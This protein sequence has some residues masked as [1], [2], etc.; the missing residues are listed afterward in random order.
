MSTVTFIVDPALGSRTQQIPQNGTH[1][2]APSEVLL[3]AA[4]GFMASACLSVF[5][6]LRIADLLGDSSKSVVELATAAGAD[7]DS[8]FRVLRA[9]EP[10]GI[11]RRT[12]PRAFA[13]TPAGALLQC[14][15]PQSMA[16]AIE[17]L[18]DPLHFQLYG[19]LRSSIDTGETTFDRLY[20]EPFFDWTSRS[21][22][23]GQATVFN[24]AMTSI[25]EMCIPAFL[26]AY[27]FSSF[28]TIVDVGGGHGA[29]LRAILKNHP[30][31]RGM[32][33]E[34]ESVVSDA[35]AAIRRD[36]LAS[37]CKAVPC[38]FFEKV[39]AGGDA[40]FM[41]H[42][43]HDWADEPAGRLLRCCWP[44]VCSTIPRRRTP[45]NSLTLK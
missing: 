39:P 28:G 25:S 16:A 45:G 44:N 9:L 15:A 21:E 10:S 12:G 42:I 6:Q 18:T 40:Y 27:K 32:V 33:A 43:V 38:N 3:Q 19:N 37:R 24:R 31:M 11:V 29:I 20:G 14:S 7:E 36:G 8:L 30:G 26:E 22:N 23:A 1:A 2:K 35:N 13:L 4:M 17:W 5:V 41:K 34:M